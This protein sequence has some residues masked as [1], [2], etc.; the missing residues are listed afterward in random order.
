MCPDPE[1]LAAFLAGNTLPPER[2]WIEEHL[3]VCDDCLWKLHVA[4]QLERTHVRATIPAP[5]RRIGS[6]WWPL[7]AAASAVVALLPLTSGPRRTPERPY[8]AQLVRATPL[9]SRFLEPRITGGFPWAPLGARRGDDALDVGAMKL[10]GAAASVLEQTATNNSTEAKHARALAHLLAGRSK[11][12]ATLL[13]DL[14]KD[15]NDARF[16]SDLAS[17]R[18]TE[19]VRT[20]AV[21]L[22]AQALAAAD[23]A[24][25]LDPRME[26]ALFNRALLVERLGARAQARAAWERYLVRDPDSAWAREAR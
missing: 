25:R 13:T 19:S 1:A 8:V 16:W 11:E 4:A 6:S 22:L 5:R 24:L 15:R 23:T 17:A 12:A 14:V 26:E 3:L 2:T 21:G 7:A 20:D 9:T 18:Y 10:V